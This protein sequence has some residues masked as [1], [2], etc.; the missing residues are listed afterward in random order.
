[1]LQGLNHTK[2]LPR[3]VFAA[4]AVVCGGE[5]VVVPVD[6]EIGQRQRGKYQNYRH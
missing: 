3:L 5:V 1:M 6:S 4:V 2:Q